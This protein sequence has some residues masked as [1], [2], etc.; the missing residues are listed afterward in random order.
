MAMRPRM[1]Q[2]KNDVLSKWSVDDAIDQYGIERWGAGLFTANSKG[3]VCLAA[4]GD[5]PEIDLKALIDEIQLRGLELPVLLRF[6]DIL[7]QRM[8]ILHKAFDAAIKENNFQGEY[9][10]VFPIKVNQHRHLLEDLVTIGKDY[11]FGLEAGSKPEL[12]IALAHHCDPESLI[13][14]NGFKDC[15]Y[16]ETALEALK[17]GIKIF[18]VVEKPAELEMILHSAKKLNVEP[19]IGIRMKLAS[20]GR[21][22]WESSGGD[23]SKFGLFCS[24]LLDA[25]QLLKRKRMLKCLQLLHFHVGSQITDI[26]R[27]K[28]TLREACSIFIEVNR[29][30]A[31]IKYLD[32]GGGLAVDYDGS[33]T[34]YASS[35]NYTEREYAADV[36]YHIA[37]A[38]QDAKIPHPTVITE[39]GRFLAAYHSVLVV[40]ALGTGSP[41]N[42]LDV[43]KLSKK[44]PELLQRIAETYTTLS[45]KNFQEAYHDAIEA[46]REALMLFN[47]RHMSL[48]DRAKIETYFWLICQKVYQ[49]SSKLDYCPDDLDGLEATLSTFYYCNF[50]VFQSVPDHWA[51]KQLFPITPLHR[52]DEKPRIEAILADITCDSDGVIDRFVDLKDVNDTLKLH[53]LKQGEP[54]YIGIF[55]VGAYQEILGDLHNLFGDTTVV[56]VSSTPQGYMIDKT[57]T[58]ETVMDVLD[59]VQFGRTDFLAQ[60]RNR[61]E[62]ALRQGNISLDESASFLRKIEMGL[63][64]YTYL[65]STHFRSQTHVCR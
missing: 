2:K 38:C 17:L 20:R 11:H 27:I 32:V 7:R 36:I 58:G 55:L 9:R 24:E 37:M 6:T 56:H 49:M 26:Q 15:D 41:A 60:V 10:G 8:G 25:I 28:T 39:S 3:N 1:Q 22:M 4:N 63:D 23:R 34:N 64:D 29:L 50:S 13:V 44:S 47:L 45:P 19:M 5:S 40:E 57:L 33:H 16:V 21:G 51:I 30:G 35:A 12:L 62:E 65:D 46:R 61:V 48:E 43:P 53:P 54:Y 18:L 42:N 14:C 59:Y 31:E 52:L